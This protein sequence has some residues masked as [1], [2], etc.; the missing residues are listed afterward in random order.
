MSKICIPSGT[1]GSFKLEQPYSFGEFWSLPKLYKEHGFIP[2]SLYLYCLGFVL[3]S[4]STRNKQLLQDKK[5]LLIQNKVEFDR[6]EK[7]KVCILL[8]DG[9]N[10]TY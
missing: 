6:L 5:M 10:F 8:E 2:I 1:P 4:L 9:I 3:Q 7:E